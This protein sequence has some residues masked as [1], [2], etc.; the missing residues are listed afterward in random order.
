VSYGKRKQNQVEEVNTKKVATVASIEREE[1]HPETTNACIKPNNHKHLNIF[2]CSL[3]KKVKVSLGQ[4]KVQ[5]LTLPLE[6][7]IIDKTSIEFIIS[8]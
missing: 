4:R 2:I 3:N 8:T 5:L 7:W 1:L 6:S